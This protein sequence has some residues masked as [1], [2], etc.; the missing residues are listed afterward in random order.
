MSTQYNV[1]AI[2]VL[3]GLWKSDGLSP[4]FVPAPSCG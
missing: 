4:L 2:E 1:D 3:N